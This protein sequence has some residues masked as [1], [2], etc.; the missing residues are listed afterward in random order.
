[1]R[2]LWRFISRTVFWSFERGSWP[3]DVLVAVI[4]V[5][6]L[7]TPRKWFHDRPREFEALSSNVQ[8]IA[9]DP[10]SR[11]RTYRLAAAALSRDKRTKKPTP[12]LERET[13]DILGRTV[14][15]LRDS[16]FQV[17]RIDPGLAS[18]GSVSYYD[19]SVHQ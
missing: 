13:H 19:V 11:V 8:L 2:T 3:Y 14:D 9:E 12:E 5:F 17:V 16:T 7:L 10:L 18:D 1:M 4:L 6:V 15:D